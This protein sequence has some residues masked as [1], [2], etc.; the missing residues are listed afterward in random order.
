MRPTKKPAPLKRIPVGTVVKW[1][2]VAGSTDPVHKGVV[3]AIPGTPGTGPSTYRVIVTKTL[4]GN[5]CTPKT[6]FPYA[7]RLEAQNFSKL[8][9]VK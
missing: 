8:R 4:K 2:A 7:S 1:Q 5:D 9:V 6:F 3:D